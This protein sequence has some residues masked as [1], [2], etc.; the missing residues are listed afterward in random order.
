MYT[1]TIHLYL[2]F[3]YIAAFFGH[4]KARKMLRGHMKAWNKLKYQID[5]NA[6]YIWFH[7]A[8]L[9]EFEQGRPLIERIKKEQPEKK[10]LL[11]FFSPS[12]YEVRKDYPYADVVCYLPFDTK[13]RVRSFLR[14]VKIEKAFFI[15]Y[16]FWR[17]YITLLKRKNIPI[18]SV[19]SIFRRKQI[20]FR[21]YGWW[22]KYMLRRFTHFFV[23][24]E[25][26]KELLATLGVNQVTVTGDTRFDRV[27]DIMKASKELPLVEEFT[28]RTE[29]QRQNPTDIEKF[30]DRFPVLVCG[31]TWPVDEDFIIPYFNRNFRMKMVLAPHVVSEEH[32]KQI[33]QRLTRPSVRYTKASIED[34]A[35]AECLIIDCYGLLSSVYRYATVTYVGG[36][37][38]VGIHNVPEAA[39]YALPVIIGP[40]NEKFREAQ[41]LLE[42]GG[43][44]EVNNGRDFEKL[45][46]M[47]FAH[48][49]LKKRAGE[50]AG[51]YIKEHAGATEKIYQFVF[52]SEEVKD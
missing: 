26:S 23:Q 27:I 40:N 29:N 48:P 2:F 19:S 30:N 37:F 17:N 31:S 16:E 52:Q 28:H 8:S 14:Y 7:A 33:E 22:Y 42:L 1:F 5:K 44:K 12:G 6:Q 49:E 47:F 20:F 13:L 10:I 21:W 32:L 15:K 35:K 45:I 39:V 25:H 4:K 11:T 50:A 34:I 38:G 24:D 3:V 51:N 18:Y 46:D 43:C 36:G 41:Q 9:G